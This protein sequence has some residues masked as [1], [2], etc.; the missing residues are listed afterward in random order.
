MEKRIV[1]LAVSLMVFVFSPAH[2]LI[3][4]LESDTDR[5]GCDFRSFAVPAPNDHDASTRI[6]SDACGLDSSCQAW[7]FDPRSGISNCFL[8]N[9]LTHPRASNGTDGGVKFSGTMG[10]TELRTDRVGCDFANFP[11]NGLQTCL[12]ACASDARCQ[13]WNFDP[14]FGA[15]TCW[16]KNCV[17]APTAVPTSDIAS[18]VKFSN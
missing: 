17:P 1:C 13:A 7:N 8:K 16:L 14:R 4:T 12:T 9:C 3:L 6:C 2:A 11:A 18:G 10:Y 15:P 5:P